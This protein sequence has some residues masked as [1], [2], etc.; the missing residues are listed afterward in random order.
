VPSERLTKDQRREAAREAARIAREKQK[1]RDRRNRIL[2]IGGSTLGLL[3]IFGVVALVLINANKPE[4]PGPQ[5]MASDGIVLLGGE[6]GMRAIETDAIEAGGKPTPTDVDDLEVP[7]LITTYIDYRCPFCNEFEVANG[8]AIEQLVES[9]IAAVEV[10]PIS[11]LDRVSAGT[12]YST[13]S[14][15]AAACVANYEPDSFLAVNAA[16]FASQPPEETTGLT[17][18]EIAAIVEG[19]GVDSADVESCIKDERFTSWVTAATNR[20]LADESLQ[21]ENGNFGTPRVLVNGQLYPGAPGDTAAFQAFVGSIYAEVEAD[22][23]ETPTPTPTA[24]TPAG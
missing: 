12:K 17:N 23:G 6:D 9:G 13:R 21:D 11:I 5:N 15:N 24:T 16:L 1:R 3:A 14:A 19:A 18:D 7:L 4:G 8:P 10:H 2:L 20:A 22:G